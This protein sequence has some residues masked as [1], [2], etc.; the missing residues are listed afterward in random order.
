MSN[1]PRWLDALR[2]RVQARFD[3]APW[4]VPLLLRVSDE[5]QS[6]CMQWPDTGGSAIDRRSFRIASVTKVYFAAAAFR[7]AEQGRLDLAAPLADAVGAET[8]KQLSRGGYDVAAITVDQVMRHTAGLR[9]HCFSDLYLDRLKA[10]PG[11]RWTRAEQIGLAM[12]LGPSLTPPGAAFAYSDTGYVILGDVVERAA[13]GDLAE[14]VPVLLGFDALGLRD[15]VWDSSGRDP[16]T[17]E[18]QYLGEHETTYW[19]ASF[20]LFGG[21][22]LVSTLADI[23]AFLRALLGGA[24]FTREATLRTIA[25]DWTTPS[26]PGFVHNG[27]MFRGE[28]SGEDVW[29]H[30]GFWGVQAALLPERGLALAATF[31]RAPEE[32]VYGKDELLADFAVAV[33]ETR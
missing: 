22:G 32:G 25:A 9:D 6:W 18:R 3:P 28:V 29:A 30:T 23:D 10:D 7:L 4:T 16:A 24:V 31:N 1:D 12:R 5:R 27:L 14:T 8:A 15:T 26:D 17:L 2:R 33:A 19:D 11:H 20:D 13:G 21:G